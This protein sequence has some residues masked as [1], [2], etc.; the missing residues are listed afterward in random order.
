MKITRKLLVPTLLLVGIGLISLL[1]VQTFNDLRD[2]TIQEQENLEFLNQAFQSRLQAMESFAVALALET[3]QNEEVQAAFAA[4]DRERLAELTLPA[5]QALDEEFNI[6]QHQ[7][8]LPPA[9]SFLRLHQPD[10]FGDDLSS[11]RFTVL[12]ANEAKQPTSGLEIGRGGLGMRGVVPVN[13]Q[14]SHIGTVEFGLNV[15]QNLIEEL[16]KQYDADWQILLSRKPAE[17]AT[18]AGSVANASGP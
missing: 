14:G 8:H 16:K 11:F 7:F 5:Y 1:L 2:S 15:D 3:A 17:I 6:P 18:F 4:R 13:Y 9:T 10:N 12:Q